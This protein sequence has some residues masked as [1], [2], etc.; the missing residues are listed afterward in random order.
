MKCPYCKNEMTSGYI[1]CRDGVTWTSKKQ[2]IAALS[3]LAVNKQSLANGAA[4]NSNTV[5]AY[6]CTECKKVII[7]YSQQP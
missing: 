7:D 5:Y 1:Q 2:P 4:D 3:A 6:N